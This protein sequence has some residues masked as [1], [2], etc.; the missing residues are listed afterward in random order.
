MLL[1]RT[2][3]VEMAHIV[4]LL[5]YTESMERKEWMQIPSFLFF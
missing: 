2:F 3:R 1:R 4:I 5:W